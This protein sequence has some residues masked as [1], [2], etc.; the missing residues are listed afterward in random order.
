VIVAAG[1]LAIA[2]GL[3]IKLALRGHRLDEITEVKVGTTELKVELTS[4]GKAAVPPNYDAKRIG[5]TQAEIKF[6]LPA[7][8]AA[9]KLQLV[10]VSPAGMSAP[11]EIVVLPTAELVEEKEPNDGFKT[12]Q[13]ISIGTT[14]AG[15]IHEPKNV[16]VFEFKAEAGQKVVITVV[17]SQVGSPLDPFLTL[18]DATGQIVGGSDDKV[19]RDPQLEVTFMKSG[20][21]FLSLQDANDAGGPHFAYLLK[22]TP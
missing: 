13:S 20:S 11:Y 1:P 21:Y 22:I 2:A 3:P 5:D 12:A 16:D 14:V 7:E 6:T 9:G 10:A 15:T 17:A 19:G 8:T 18:Y 4:K